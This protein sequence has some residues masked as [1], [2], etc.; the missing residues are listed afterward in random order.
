SALA[1]SGEETYVYL[2]IFDDTM[3]G[4]VEY[5]VSDLGDVLGIEIGQDLES[6]RIA[7]SENL[8]AILEY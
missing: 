5:P 7:V 1:H 8:D 4:R 3:E 6:A 2:E